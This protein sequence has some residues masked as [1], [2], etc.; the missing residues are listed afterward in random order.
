VFGRPTPPPARAQRRVVS[1]WEAHGSTVTCVRERNVPSGQRYT[2]SVS[3]LRCLVVEGQKPQEGIFRIYAGS[4]AGGW[5]RWSAPEARFSLIVLR[6][7]C[8][9]AWKNGRGEAQEWTCYAWHGLQAMGKTLERERKLR[10]G[11]ATAVDVTVRLVERIHR[12]SKAL[13]VAKGL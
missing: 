8:C 5:N 11:S 7:L 2:G 3:S 1:P 10:R 13:K 4:R 9:R 12:W 6:H